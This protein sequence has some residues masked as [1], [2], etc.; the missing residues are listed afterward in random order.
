MDYVT[1]QLPLSRR[2]VSDFFSAGSF[3]VPR[4]CE[5]K[6]KKTLKMKF[7]AF[8]T[9]CKL[10][11]HENTNGANISLYEFTTTFCEFVETLSFPLR[12]AGAAAQNTV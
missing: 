1:N 9:G 2:R 12:A 5:A 6:F 4:K 10:I 7:R 11:E 3:Q 8:S